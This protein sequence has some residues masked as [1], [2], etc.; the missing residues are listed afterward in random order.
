MEIIQMRNFIEAADGYV[1]VLNEAI[2]ESV[3]PEVI[4]PVPSVHPVIADLHNLT[5]K[6]RAFMESREGDFGLG[7]EIGMQRA[8]DMIDNLLH[9]HEE[10]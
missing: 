3:E 8:A 9:R 4:V 1:S 5:F 7:V 10:S 2:N 6:L